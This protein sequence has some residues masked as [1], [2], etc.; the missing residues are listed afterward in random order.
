MPSPTAVTTGRVGCWARAASATTFRLP[1]RP[2][3]KTLPRVASEMALHVLK[4][5]AS[6]RAREAHGADLLSC[7]GHVATRLVL[8]KLTFKDAL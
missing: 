4:Q 7:C 5:L 2:T 1:S 6:L 3:I 8:A